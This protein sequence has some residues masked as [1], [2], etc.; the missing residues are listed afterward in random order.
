MSESDTANERRALSPARLL[1]LGICVTLGSVINGINYTAINVTLEGISNSL[2]VKDGDLQWAANS[3]LL[4]FVS[5]TDRPAHEYGR[6]HGDADNSC[7]ST[8]QGGTSLVSGR[9]ADLLG[10]YMQCIR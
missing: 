1:L 2:K 9:A 4:A 3:S 6:H 7:I 5:S 10:E 8:L